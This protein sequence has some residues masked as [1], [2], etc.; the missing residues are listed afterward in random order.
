MNTENMTNA[1]NS[2]RDSMVKVKNE[3]KNLTETKNKLEEEKNKLVSQ[4]S[5]LNQKNVN[6]K[7]EIVQYKSK[8]EESTSNYQK[9]EKN[10]KDLQSQNQKLVEEIDALHTKNKDGK[11]KMASVIFTNWVNVYDALDQ[12]LVNAKQSKLADI[13]FTTV[14]HTSYILD[15]IFKLQPE[16]EEPEKK[17]RTIKEEL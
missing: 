14:K 15:K 10:M 17:P 3:N 2:V 16:P 13:E 8:L 12:K 7:K 1:Y 6:C 5:E 9:I 4:N 11:V